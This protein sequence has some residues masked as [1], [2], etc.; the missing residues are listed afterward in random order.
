M[1]AT[2][3]LCFV[4]AIFAILIFAILH[5]D[6]RAWFALTGGASGLGRATA[7]R[8]ARVG[9][10][11]VIADL[12]GSDG[13]AVAEA[14]GDNAVFAPTDVTSEAD[15]SAALDAAEATF[16]A[17]VNAAVNCAGIGVAVKT[18]NPKKGPHPLDL[19]NKVLA[20]NTGGSF[21]VIRLASE[22]MAG[23]DGD[24]TDS[25]PG[26]RGVIVNTASVAAFDGQVG[27]AAYS[28]SKG[29]IVGMTLPIA[30]DLAKTGIRVCTI[31]PGLF[32]TPL[33]ASLPD[34]VKLELGQQVPF[35]P[36]LGDPDEY[37]RLVQ[38][39]IENPMM[40]GETIRLDGAIR[41]MP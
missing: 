1:C 23:G 41:M 21:N 3:L 7:E 2:I 37:G 36:R 15:V 32:D 4:R 9:A 5:G 20:V 31:A 38:H 30:R 6:T 18:Y 8:L 33:L 19:F 40:N 27:Q 22:R 34:K 17:S 16:G 35:P 39:I 28:A 24:G 14:I 11:V 13:A 10:R 26:C 25:G 12:P 29:A